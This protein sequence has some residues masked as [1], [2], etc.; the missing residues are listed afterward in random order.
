[1]LLRFT[2]GVGLGG[3]SGRSGG[4]ALLPCVLIPTPGLCGPCGLKVTVRA[5]AC[6]A[7]G[8]AGA[9]GCR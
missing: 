9:D 1:M 6:T 7:G 5:G 4:S 2:G 3:V 8:S